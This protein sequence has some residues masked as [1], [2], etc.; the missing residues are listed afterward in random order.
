VYAAALYLEMP[1]QDAAQV[2]SP[3]DGDLKDGML[4]KD[5]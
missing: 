4:G 1:T 2:I 5:D 3:V